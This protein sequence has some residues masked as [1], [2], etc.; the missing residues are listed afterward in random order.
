MVAQD[1]N[2]QE[3]LEARQAIA[4]CDEVNA[5]GGKKLINWLQLQPEDDPD[6]YIGVH[7]ED[8]TLIGPNIRIGQRYRIVYSAPVR[9]PFKD[10][11]GPAVFHIAEIEGTLVTIFLMSDVHCII[12]MP[13]DY[14]VRETM[15]AER[16]FFRFFVGDALELLKN[17]SS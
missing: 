6:V 17:G 15:S 4:W 14:T 8:S 1:G 5:E 2:I 13:D 3:L 7:P 9:L 11:E 10:N 16:S 12:C